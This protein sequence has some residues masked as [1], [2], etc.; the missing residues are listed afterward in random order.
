MEEEKL[1]N[2]LKISIHAHPAYFGSELACPECNPICHKSHGMGKSNWCGHEKCPMNPKN[3]KK[4]QVD[5]KENK[6]FYP[7]L[8]IK[9]IDKI[10]ELNMDLLDAHQWKHLLPERRKE[11]LEKYGMKER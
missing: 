2:R 6:M 8:I 4:K 11:L 9:I 7:E 10:K 3:F 1:E 5:E